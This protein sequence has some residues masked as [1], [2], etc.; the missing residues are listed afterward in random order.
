MH[1]FKLDKPTD[2]HPDM[3]L[4]HLGNILKEAFG[5]INFQHRKP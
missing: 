4:R 5:W 2:I 1:A 3:D